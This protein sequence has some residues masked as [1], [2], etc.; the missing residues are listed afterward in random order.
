MRNKIEYSMNSNEIRERIDFLN[1]I[2]ENLFLILN[3]NEFYIPDH[4]LNLM[5]KSLEEEFDC[6]IMS[7]KPNKLGNPSSRNLCNLICPATLTHDQ[8]LKLITC[9]SKFKGTIFVA[10]AKPLKFLACK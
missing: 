1:L 7:Y 10:Y 4:E 5:R 6:Y 8:A 9:E 3:F 2:P